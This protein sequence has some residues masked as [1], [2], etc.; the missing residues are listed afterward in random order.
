MIKD[1]FKSPMDFILANRINYAKD[2]P[3]KIVK[4]IK[5]DYFV[6][7]SNYRETDDR[8]FLSDCFMVGDTHLIDS[9]VINK[10]FLVAIER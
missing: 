3:I 10:A 4:T 6:D 7:S 1:E 2:N 8:I 9:V 5:N